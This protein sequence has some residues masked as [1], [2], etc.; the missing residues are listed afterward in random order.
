MI[1]IQRESKEVVTEIYME[2]LQILP[3]KLSYTAVSMWVLYVAIYSR[4]LVTKV[5]L[6]VW[7]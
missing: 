6:N 1:I 5:E 2:S 7:T 4:G 3:H